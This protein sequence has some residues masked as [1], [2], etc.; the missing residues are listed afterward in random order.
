VL[1]GSL[2]EWLFVADKDIATHIVSFRKFEPL[3]WT[4]KDT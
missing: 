2:G 3:V 4:R 1:S